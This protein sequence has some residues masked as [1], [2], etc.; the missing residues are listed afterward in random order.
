M[1]RLPAVL[2]PLLSLALAGCAQPPPAA[3]EDFGAPIEAGS[4]RV[5]EEPAEPDPPASPAQPAGSEPAPPAGPNGTANPDPGT[6]SPPGGEATNGTQGE[7][8]QPTQPGPVTR[9]GAKPKPKPG[10]LPTWHVGDRWTFQGVD[11]QGARYDFIRTV[12]GSVNVSGQ[13]AWTLEVQQGAERAGRNVTRAGLN[14]INETGFVTEL[15]RFPLVAGASWSYGWSVDGTVGGSPFG[16]RL[17][18]NVQVLGLE[19]KALA[20]GTMRL[21]HL[22]ADVLHKAGFMERTLRVD[23][24]YSDRAKEIV[25]VEQLLPEGA[26]AWEELV[27]AQLAA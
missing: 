20:M 3:P 16:E 10:E 6:L 19:D 23:Y 4:I 9:P 7:P 15:L 1:A 27:D 24:W 22:H 21:W 11:G 17:E 26:R 25:R 2:L 18:G 5:D 14:P 13:A 12:A 8:Q